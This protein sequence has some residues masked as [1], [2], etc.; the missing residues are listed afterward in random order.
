MTTF[1]LIL[2]LNTVSLR[3]LT[4][5]T[6]ELVHVSRMRV[7][8]LEDKCLHIRGQSIYLGINHFESNCSN[9]S[10]EDT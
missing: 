2:K 4:L 10:A 8:Y 3:V 9:L 1:I 5:S 6:A 7:L